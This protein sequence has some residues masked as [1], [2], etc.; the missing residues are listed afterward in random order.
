MARAMLGL[1]I[2]LFRSFVYPLPNVIRF[3]ID[4]GAECKY[5][6]QN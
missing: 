4:I 2:F 6:G 5:L 3:R 1:E